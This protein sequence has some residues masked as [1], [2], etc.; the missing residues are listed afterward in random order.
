MNIRLKLAHLYPQA[1][2]LYGDTGNII[3]LKRRCQWRGIELEVESIHIGDSLTPSHYDLVFI[4]GGQDRQQRLVS[5]DL[6]TKASALKQMAKAGVPMLAICGG[7]QLFGS[8]YQPAEGAKLP[9]INLLDIFT[10]AGNKRLIGNI[11][12]DCQINSSKHTVVGFENHSGKTYL[13]SSAKPLGRVLLGY[14]NNGEDKTEGA[15][16]NNVFGT[17]M[18]GSLLPKNPWLADILISL[19]VKRRLGKVDLQPLDD[20]LEEKAHL[21]AISH[22]KKLQRRKWVPGWLRK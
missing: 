3:A 7:Y 21:Q 10:I 22:A 20:S 17:Y 15:R 8:Y 2:N 12:V 11:V 14:G 16:Q 19:A 9:G 13:G 5:S 1:M 18:H 6:L 4:G